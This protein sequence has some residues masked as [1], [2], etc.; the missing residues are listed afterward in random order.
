MKLKN[1][2]LGIAFHLLKDFR[3]FFYNSMM[4]KSF[5]TGLEPEEVIMRKTAMENIASSAQ[6]KV[7]YITKNVQ[8]HAKLIK[9]DK[10]NLSWF[11]K[12]K[13]KHVTYIL[14]K[15][16]FF[17]F[18]VNEGDAIHVMY[19][20]VDDK[21]PG[22]TLGD[23]YGDDIPTHLKTLKDLPI[24][25]WDVFV[26]RLKDSINGYMPEIPCQN[27]EDKKLFVQLLLFIELST[28]TIKML[29]PNQKIIV[30]V[31]EKSQNNRVKNESGTGVI[32]V[33]T[34]WNKTLIVSG[35][36]DVRGHIRIQ[37]YGPQRSDYKPV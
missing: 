26:I 6:N 30:P 17:R 31:H 15:N 24:A 22:V 34:T 27:P 4:S 21:Y 23:T 11:K 7:F 5:T 33:D 20:T 14:N 28:V 2:F 18:W 32:Y 1:D 12:I 8:D 9:F 36:F 13:T 37:P 3:Q 19:G 10:I 29:A 16:E 25:K 35:E